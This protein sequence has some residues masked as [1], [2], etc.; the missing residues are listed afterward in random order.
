M[1]VFLINLDKNKDRL[2]R[3]TLRLNALGVSFERVEAIY[4]KDLSIDDK[5]KA[6]N[7]FRWWCAQGRKVRDGEIGCALSHFKIYQ[8]MQDER[9]ECACILEDDNIYSDE[10][11]TVLNQVEKLM[12]PSLPQVVL[13]SNY[14]DA[15]PVSKEVKISSTRN[16]YTTASYIITRLAASALMR[17]NYPIQ[18]PCD[19]GRRWVRRNI[20]SLYHSIPAVCK[21]EDRKIYGSDVETPDMERVSDFGPLKWLVHKLKRLIGVTIDRMLPL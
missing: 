7:N 15:V 3:S 11:S 8:K 19:Y 10:F 2:E 5:K 9:I 17:A 6:V 4:G 18:V 1:R 20:I 13:L 14:T 21:Q 12:D 16:D